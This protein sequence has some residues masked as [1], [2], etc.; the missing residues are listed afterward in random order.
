MTDLMGMQKDRNAHFI[1]AE[2]EEVM[3][4]YPGQP[5]ELEAKP[6]EEGKF[7]IEKEEKIES[8]IKVSTK[9]YTIQKKDTLWKIAQK[10]LGSG[11]RWKYLY[12]LNKDK[13]NNPNKLKPGITI[14]I[15]I[16]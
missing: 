10:H 1:I 5:Q 8:A 7:L 15:P 4:P 9:E 3:I 14:T 11:H 12:E 6:I 16:E 13:I 2:V